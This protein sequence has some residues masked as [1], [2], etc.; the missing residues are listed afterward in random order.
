MKEKKPN[1]IVLGWREIVHLPNLKIKDLPAKVDTGARTSSLHAEDISVVEKK[2]GK[3]VEFSVLVTKNGRTK[4]TKCRAKL[5]TQKKIRS[6]TGHAEVRPIIMTMIQMGD[7]LFETPI[8]LTNREEM[9]FKMLI[10][11]KTIKHGF[12]VDPAKSF[13]L[14]KLTGEK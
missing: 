6:S 1:K 7:V 11:R 14:K 13:Q 2:S 12:M 9:G 10:G 5:V 4:K 8:T 3:N